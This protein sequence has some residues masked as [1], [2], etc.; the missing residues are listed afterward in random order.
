[1]ANILVVDDEEMDRLFERTILERAGHAL[2][3]AG[4]GKAALE[5]Y[6]RVAI[7]LVVTDLK[8]PRLNGLQLIRELRDLDADV[9]VLAVSGASADQLILAEDLGAVQTL[10]KPLDPAALL[11]AVEAGLSRRKGRGDAW[12]AR[13]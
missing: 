11:Q 1:M 8:M 2:F 6:R 10:F 3:F 9:P 12:G 4:D 5:V 7:D 13:G